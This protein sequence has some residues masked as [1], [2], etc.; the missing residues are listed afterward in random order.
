MLWSHPGKSIRSLM[1][2]TLHETW[3]Q[4]CIGV[5][6]IYVHLR[7]WVKVCTMRGSRDEDGRGKLVQRVGDAQSMPGVERALRIIVYY[8]KAG[9]LNNSL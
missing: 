5:K 3:V 9:T 8:K 1:I 6:T 7:L 4:H 2:C